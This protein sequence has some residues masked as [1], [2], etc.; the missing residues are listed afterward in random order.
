MR[1]F[2]TLDRYL[3][4]IQTLKKKFLCVR[5]VDVAHY[6]EVSKAS[7][8]LAVR[9]L[10]EKGFL[11]V[12]PDGNLLYTAQGRDRVD[13]LNDRVDFFRRTLTDAG[14]EPSLAIQDAISI[15]WEMSEASYEALRARMEASERPPQGD[16]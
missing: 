11:E 12:E 5:S 8:S 13:L 3:Y 4:A 10:R 1:K 7:V 14:V 9:Q 6:M 16:Q 2:T 15:S